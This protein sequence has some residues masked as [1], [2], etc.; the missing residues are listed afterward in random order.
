M[1]ETGIV[2]PISDILEIQSESVHLGPE[3]WS[4]DY[5]RRLIIER[6]WVRI[7]ALYTGWTRHFFT[8]I[9]CKNCL[10]E[11]AENKL[12][13]GRC[14]PIFKNIGASNYFFIFCVGQIL[15]KLI[16]CIFPEMTS[17]SY[18]YRLRSFPAYN[19]QYFFLKLSP[20]ISETRS[21][22]VQNRLQ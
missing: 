13:R 4:S 1:R 17:R 22:I 11:R 5:G 12:K 8:L 15:S 2:L 16:Y 14:W 19:V 21:K 7:P 18:F 20:K 9:C 6:S 3:P 10:F